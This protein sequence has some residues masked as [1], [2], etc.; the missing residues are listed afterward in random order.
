[1]K[2]VEAWISKHNDNPGSH[3]LRDKKALH[4]AQETATVNKRGLRRKRNLVFIEKTAYEEEYGKATDNGLSYDKKVIDGVEVEGVWVQE[5]KKGHHRFEEYEDNSVEC[6]TIVDDGQ[7]EL[8]AGQSRRKF[9]LLSD[10][11]QEENSKLKKGPCMDD[12]LEIAKKRTADAG[13]GEL[14]GDGAAGCESDG[15][16]SEGCH[17]SEDEAHDRR[18]SLLVGLTAKPRGPAA[19]AK[20][21]APKPSPAKSV[22]SAPSQRSTGASSSCKPR[23]PLKAKDLEALESSAAS[24]RA[25]SP[26]R[27]GRFGRRTP[28][29]AEASKLRSVV[30]LDGRGERL[31]SSIDEGLS[32]IKAQAVTMLDLNI[33]CES[34]ACP[35]DDQDFQKAAKDKLAIMGKAVSSLTQLILRTQRSANK[36]LLSG[37]LKEMEELRD[38]VRAAEA[39]IKVVNQKGC[40]PEAVIA[41]VS[42]ADELEFA[43]SSPFRVAALYAL[44]EQAVMYSKY[45]DLCELLS[46]GSPTANFLFRLSKRSLT[47]YA[48]ADA[49][50]T[51]WCA[52]RLTSLTYDLLTYAMPARYP[53]ASPISF[54]VVVVEGALG[55]A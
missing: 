34:P 44:A 2:S 53:N 32:E 50:F 15:Q 13:E 37:S 25:S 49:E 14:D 22:S 41:A 51:P 39:A 52:V 55:F 11:M 31:K 46:H 18:R 12:L 35:T 10:A 17:D 3:R 43:M 36:D 21:S 30:A 16:E 19:K 33:P 48:N 5:G 6:K 7:G 4:D 47:S 40:Q 27:S 54:L 45:Q 20:G 24:E 29:K 1:M 8:E 23:T 38:K 26:A 9:E 28:S 42:K